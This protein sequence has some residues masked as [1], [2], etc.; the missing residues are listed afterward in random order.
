MK[1]TRNESGICFLEF[2][3]IPLTRGSGN[4]NSNHMRIKFDMEDEK[5]RTRGLIRKWE[6]MR[7]L[8]GMVKKKSRDG[9]SEFEALG[10]GSYYEGKEV[11]SVWDA[12]GIFHVIS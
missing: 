8:K 9:K 10:L 2:A 11:N 7:K 3:L 5:G 6:V 1:Y 12:D 4:V